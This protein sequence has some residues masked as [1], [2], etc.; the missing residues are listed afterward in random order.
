[1]AM[2]RGA[3]ADSGP[4]VLGASGNRGGG[5]WQGVGMHTGIGSRLGPHGQWELW[6]WLPWGRRAQLLWRL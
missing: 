2:V 6:S 5:R 3:V 4:K 1:M